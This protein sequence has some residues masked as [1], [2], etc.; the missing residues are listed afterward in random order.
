MI[1]NEQEFVRWLKQIA[2][3]PR[4]RLKLGIGDDA[5]MMAVSPGRDLILTTDLTIENVHFTH[6]L[7]S[8]RSVGHRA[9]ARSLSDVAA[10]GGEPRVALVSIA[11]SERTTRAWV[12]RFYSGFLALAKTHGVAVIG[13]D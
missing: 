10:M 8:A 4:G 1:K 9:L 7:H 12:K 3:K 13:G 2:P 11:L 6:T 5:A